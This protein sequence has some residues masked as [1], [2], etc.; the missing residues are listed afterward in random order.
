ME[1]IETFDEHLKTLMQNHEFAN[2]Y[3][4]EKKHLGLA[5]KLTEYRQKQGITQTELARRSGITQQQLSKLERGENCNISTFLKV[6]S[7]LDVEVK[8]NQ[9]PFST[10]AKMI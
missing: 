1:K 8:L 7:C 6:C 3:A 9:K 5:I 4:E 10:N 2:G